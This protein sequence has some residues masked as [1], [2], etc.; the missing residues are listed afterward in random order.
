MRNTPWSHVKSVALILIGTLS[1]LGWPAISNATKYYVSNN[2]IAI[3]PRCT[4]INLPC[5][6]QSAFKN[7]AAGD[8]VYFRGGTYTVPQK[9]VGD[10][11]TSYYMPSHSG[12]ASTWITF[13]AYPGEVPVFNGTSGGTGD[14]YGTNGYIGCKVMGVRHQEYIILDGFTILCDGGT[15]MGG[16]TIGG[17]DGVIPGPFPT[18]YVIIQNCTINGGSTVNTGTDNADGI[19]INSAGN[20]TI[21][22][23][24]IFNFRQSTNYPNTAATKAYHTMDV[25]YENNYIYDSTAAIYDKSG[26]LR[27]T[28]RYNFIRNVHYGI[29]IPTNSYRHL[30]GTVNHNI[31]VNASVIGIDV[32]SENAIVPY[33]STDWVISN[34][35]IYSATPAKGHPIAVAGQGFVNGLTGYSIYN[36]V[37]AQAGTDYG[38]ANLRTG[39]DP[40]AGLVTSGLALDYNNYGANMSVRLIAGGSGINYTTVS[41]LRAVAAYN[42]AREAHD[43]HSI[44]SA[45]LFT[46][47]SGTYS[48]PS[49]FALV[50]ES[51]GYHAGSDGGDMGADVTLVGISDAAAQAIQQGGTLPPPPTDLKISCFPCN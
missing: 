5:S 36:N 34:N 23:N 22:R 51:P 12:T 33:L 32:T 44:A 40:V 47:R 1:A 38:K 24:T 11:Y 2:G 30:N 37:I 4:D 3:W 39:I 20:I 18:N 19:R 45:P 17:T 10:S 31:I 49:D 28:Y 48:T 46:N 9:D 29:H 14:L 42:L 13:Q 25:V 26:G 43:Q 6:A 21:R 15:K 16:M 50:V 8:I 27:N 35:T 41:G 7:A